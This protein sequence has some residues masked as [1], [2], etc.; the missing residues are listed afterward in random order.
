MVLQSVTCIIHDKNQFKKLSISNSWLIRH[1]FS[2][3]SSNRQFILINPFWG[4]RETE[5][6]H[7]LLYYDVFIKL[8]CKYIWINWCSHKRT[9]WNKLKL[10]LLNKIIFYGWIDSNILKLRWLTYWR[11]ISMTENVLPKS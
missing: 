6:S 8:L 4:G 7:P 10:C 9:R 11:S 1:K 3:S 2:T 5:G